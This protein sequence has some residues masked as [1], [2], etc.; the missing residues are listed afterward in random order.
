MKHLFIINPAAG[1][2]SSAETLTEQIEQV[3]RELGDEYAIRLTEHPGHATELVREYLADGEEWRVYACGGDGTL[4][5]VVCGAAGFPNCAISQIACGTGND[6]LRMFEGGSAAFRDVMQVVT[7]EEREFDLMEA[8]GHH[9]INI[10]SVG[11]DARVAATVHSFSKFPGITPFAAFTISAV[12]NLC[13][14]F[15]N[16]YRIKIDGPDGEVKIDGSCALI[17]IAS[18]R[19]YGGGYMPIPDADPADGL[20]DILVVGHASRL[21]VPPLLAHYKA[22]RYEK[23]RDWKV[24]VWRVRA[25]S[26]EVDLCGRKGILNADGE[27]IPAE[28]AVVRL[29]DKRMRF[30]APKGCFAEIDKMRSEREKMLETAAF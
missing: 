4:N 11:F 18:A 14:G 7:G 12:Y 19:Y 1:K 16:K 15:C 2:R 10:C 8:N 26:I 20:M 21:K 23:I 27:V 5:E 13:K 29:S 24:D 3:M 6:F 25:T 22:G 17:C 30:F 28:R 9:A